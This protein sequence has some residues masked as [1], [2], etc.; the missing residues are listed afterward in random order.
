M[1]QQ[2]SLSNN[3]QLI[4]SISKKNFQLPKQPIDH[5]GIL[6]MRS[7]PFRNCVRISDSPRLFL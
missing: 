4:R 3:Q 5:E 7:V 1:G 6:K 2:E